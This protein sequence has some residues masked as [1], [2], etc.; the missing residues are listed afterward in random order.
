[1][2]AGVTGACITTWVTFAPCFLWIFLGA[3]YIESLRSNR[4]LA[5]ALSGVTA[6]VVGVLLNLA[7]W[8]GVQVMFAQTADMSGSGALVNFTIFQPLVLCSFDVVA[9]II[10]L[11]SLAAICLLKAG[12]ITVVVVS[13][14]AG[15]VANFAGPT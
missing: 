10:V 3:P 11:L 13:A 12:V 4:S 5:S 1:M 9:A 15:L 8:F 6:A 14:T 2:L 7:I